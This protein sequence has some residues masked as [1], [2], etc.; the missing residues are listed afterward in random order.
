M[1]FQKYEIA[2]GTYEGYSGYSSSSM[3]SNSDIDTLSSLSSSSEGLP[4]LPTSH[5]WHLCGFRCSQ[6][7]PDARL[8]P[9]IRWFT[10]KKSGSRIY[11]QEGIFDNSKVDFLNMVL[12]Y[13]IIWIRIRVCTVF[14]FGCFWVAMHETCQFF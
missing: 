3:R 6:I 11:Q 7:A 13:P 4:P 2:C 10:L 5:P 9:A 12:F 1:G 8:W 14:A